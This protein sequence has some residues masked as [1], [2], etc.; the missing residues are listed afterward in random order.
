MSFKLV[1]K[2]LE[3][4]SNGRRHIAVLADIIRAVYLWDTGGG[5][6]C[7]C[8][9]VCYGEFPREVTQGHFYA[10]MRLGTDFFVLVMEM[11]TQARGSP[12][13]DALVVLCFHMMMLMFLG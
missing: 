4:G 10:S 6:L 2:L 5:W 11:G 1:R 9:M 13:V 8:D 3:I 12:D 7:D